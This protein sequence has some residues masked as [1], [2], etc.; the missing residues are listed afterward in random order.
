[1]RNRCSWTTP[2]AVHP[3]LVRRPRDTIIGAVVAL[4]NTFDEKPTRTVRSSSVMATR[5]EPGQPGARTVEVA[6]GADRRSASRANSTTSATSAATP[7]RA[8]ASE[9]AWA[10]PPIAGGPATRPT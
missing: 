6:K 10:M 3:R 2:L 9:V 5:T 7:L 4:E 1:M 8:T